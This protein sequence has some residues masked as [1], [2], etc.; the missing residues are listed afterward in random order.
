MNIKSLIQQIW[1]SLAVIFVL[2]IVLCGVYPLLVWGIGQVAFHDRANGSLVELHGQV[3]GSSLI[4]QNFTGAK[5]FHPRPSG[6]GDDGYDAANSGASNLGPLSQKL[7]DQVEE[8]VKAYRT[9]NSLPPSV[10]VPADAVTE[11]ASGLDPDISETNAQLQAPRVA[12]ARA[13]SAD[14]VRQFIARFAAGRQLGFLGEPRVNVLRLNLALDQ[15][16]KK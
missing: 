6:A 2:G 14:V 4:A 3:A 12:Q 9:E 1:A 10:K 11:S 5:Y 7:H 16:N 8:R 15:S 13:M